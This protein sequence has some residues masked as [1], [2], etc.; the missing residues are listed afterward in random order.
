MGGADG[1]PAEPRAPVLRAV[2]LIW[3]AW[4]AGVAAVLALGDATGLVEESERPGS[5]LWPLF[6]WDFDLYRYVADNGYRHGETPEYA[7]FPVWPL[8]LWASEPVADWV[9]AGMLAVAASLAA[10]AGVARAAPGLDARRVAL[11]LACLPGSYALA[12]AYPDA[13]AIAAGAWAC[14]LLAEGR[15]AASALLAAVAAAAR[16]PGFLVALPLAAL[17]RGRGWRAWA[18]VAS[19]LVASVA[20]HLYFWRRHGEP[21]AFL[22]AQRM[23]GRGGIGHWLSSAS[24]RALALLAAAA[25]AT[26]LVA[27]ALRGRRRLPLVAA[28]YLVAAAA[29]VFVAGSTQTR[30]EA[31]RA[32]LVTFPL[33]GTLWLMPARYRPWA[34][35]ATAVLALSLL[36]G[37]L[38]SFGRQSLLAFPLVWAAVFVVAGRRRW[39]YVAGAAGNAALLLAL[40]HFAP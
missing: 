27:L 5:F 18:A 24:G 34:L 19:P 30:V 15:A 8:L 20:V 22:L 17:A 6:A 39:L 23:W 21:D 16:P 37:S 33:L 29:L 9:A 4:A 26:L 12:L 7:F 32:A 38:Q 31:A 1:A 13:L 40:P 36:S 35:F 3:L 2:L 14:A 10:F 25:L 11:A 28:G